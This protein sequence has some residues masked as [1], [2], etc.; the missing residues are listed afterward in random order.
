MILK[1]I[2]FLS[3]CSAIAAV[4]FTGS[5]SAQDRARVIKPNSSQPVNQPPI[6]APAPEQKSKP[7]SS[8]SHPVLTT[9]ID[10]A[11][12]DSAGDVKTAPEP[13]VIKTASSK[14]VNAAPNFAA[15]KTAYGPA[16]S[17]K[18]D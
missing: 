2:F 6:Q 5:V 3:V 10:V 18:L 1:K 14:P 16:V 8:S 12:P 11:K 17:V 4:N 13:L 15:A 9:K 7:I